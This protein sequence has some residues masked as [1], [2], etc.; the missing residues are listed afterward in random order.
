MSLAHWSSSNK[1]RK[2]RHKVP[3]AVQLVN[4]KEKNNKIE[5]MEDPLGC[6][7]REIAPCDFFMKIRTFFH[8]TLTSACLVDS[9]L[10]RDLAFGK[11][12]T[13]ETCILLI[14][15]GSQ[16]LRGLW[17]PRLGVVGPVKW[18]VLWARSGHPIWVRFWVSWA[19]RDHVDPS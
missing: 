12:P 6:S 17:A 15:I 16:M 5:C 13:L 4:P 3:T 10:D 2:Y 8:L 18:L 19:L 14:F 9:F 1:E 11:L 7:L